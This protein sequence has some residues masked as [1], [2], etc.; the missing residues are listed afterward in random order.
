ML[1]KKKLFIHFIQ[2]GIGV[3]FNRFMQVVW[4]HCIVQLPCHGHPI[5]VCD[6]LTRITRHR[7]Y[8]SLFWI[9]F[10]IFGCDRK[11]LECR[12][13]PW[14]SLWEDQISLGQ[15]PATT[16]TPDNHLTH[17]LCSFKFFRFCD[18]LCS[19]SISSDQFLWRLCIILFWFSSSKKFQ[20]IQWL[21]P[22]QSSATSFS[23]IWEITAPNSVK[24][25]PPPPPV[26]P[27]G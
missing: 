15:F 6:V 22:C 12:D 10:P 3:A 18:N 27:C 19:N 21:E 1:S 11:F 4:L 7:L 8:G 5:R 20:T 14:T 17:R 13:A 16:F 9:N 25:Q 2:L 26:D 24:C 23:Y